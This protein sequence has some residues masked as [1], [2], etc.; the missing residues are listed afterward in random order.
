MPTTTRAKKSP[1]IASRARGARAPAKSAS[2]RDE[3]AR[4][5]SAASAR[6]REPSFFSRHARV[7]AYVP[8]LVG[9]ARIALAVVALRRAFAD[10]RTC[11]LCYFASF[12][13]D[14]LDGVLARRYDQ[15]SEFGRALD[16]ITDRL[17]TSGLLVVLAVERPEAYAACVGLLALDVA[18]HWT[19]E[20]VQLMLG[21]ESHKCVGEDSCFVLRWYYGNR[22][23][24][25][26]CCVS[27][28][29][30]YLCLHA[31]R[32]DPTFV[33]FRALGPLTFSALARLAI[34]GFV[35]KQIANCA[36]LF[37]ACQTLMRIDRVAM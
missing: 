18:S 32:A 6:A 24:M 1:S 5:K 31:M 27:A 16:M 3:S 9:Y 37:E 22:I 23:F 30:L 26:A 10:A 28:E 21:N 7:Y 34:P 4:R 2:A 35:V 33:G 13:C 20:R 17:A 36:Q 15:C 29:V 14:A 19:H 12:A 8:N 11:V 25:G